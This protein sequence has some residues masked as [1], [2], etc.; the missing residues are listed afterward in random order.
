MVVINSFKS[1]SEAARMN[2]SFP[3][4]WEFSTYLDVIQKGNLIRGLLNSLLYAGVATIIGVTCC[5]MAAFVLSR[6][7]T[8]LN[9]FIYY[10]I[11]C[12]LFFPVNYVTLVR[13]FQWFHLTN[14]R[15]GIIVVYSA[16]M[17][18]FCIFTIYSFVE[19]V[20]KSMDEA[21]ILDGANPVKMFF[22]VIAPMMKPTLVTCFILEFMGS[23]NDFMTP[24]YLS[25]KSE[26]FP[27][28][29][30]VYQFF[31]RNTSYWNMIFA[32]IVL[33]VIP[34]LIIYAA[35]QKYLVSGTTS[36]AVKE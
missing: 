30:S 9:N 29:M 24:L 10:F 33:T 18:P 7:R 35:G 28:T 6:N 31:G 22:M 2:L 32:D 26:L 36:G 23:W 13:V 27:V 14:T 15:L 21:A 1:R 17:I 5:A 4:V 19:T 3:K 34:V 25:T 8:K 16:M 11:I 20:P 12:G